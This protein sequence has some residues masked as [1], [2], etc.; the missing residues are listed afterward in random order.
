MYAAGSPLN[1]EAGMMRA[2]IVPVELSWKL[3][4]SGFYVKSSLGMYVPDG[5]V[6]GVN[7]LGNLGPPDGPAQLEPRRRWLDPARLNNL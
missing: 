3:G 2:F 6:T 7:G 4:D 1:A 5:T